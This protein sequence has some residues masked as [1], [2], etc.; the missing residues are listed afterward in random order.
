[1]PQRCFLN[2][3]GTCLPAHDQPAG[4]AAVRHTAWHARSTPRGAAAQ[5][6]VSR[7]PACA[8][9]GNRPQQQ[10]QR[11]HELGQ[12]VQGDA[13]QLPSQ[14]CLRP[15]ARAGGTHPLQ[16]IRLA[17]AALVRISTSPNP[18]RCRRASVL[19]IAC[20]LPAVSGHSPCL[21]PQQLPRATFVVLLVSSI[22]SRWPRRGARLRAAQ[23]PGSGGASRRRPAQQ[24]SSGRARAA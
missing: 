8:A 18:G 4:A 20:R 3:G 9:A 11:H 23:A 6:N 24:G 15:S 21:G 13:A 5:S 14:R 7:Q 19:I 22:C 12:A 2:A 10:H 16:L 1:M 17:L